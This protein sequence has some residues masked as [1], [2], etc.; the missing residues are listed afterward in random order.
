MRC[1]TRGVGDDRLAER[2]VRR[3]QHDRQD[4]GLRRRWVAEHAATTTAPSRIVSGRPKASSRTGTRALPAQRTEIDARRVGEAAP[5]RASPRPAPARPSSC[6][7]RRSRRALSARPEDRTRQ[8]ASLGSA[9]SRPSGCET[10]ATPS[11]ATATSASAHSI[12]EHAPCSSAA[13]VLLGTPRRPGLPIRSIN[14]IG[15]DQPQRRSPTGHLSSVTRPHH[16]DWM[17]PSGTTAVAGFPR[18]NGTV[19]PMARGRG[20]VILGQRALP[21]QREA[22]MESGRIDQTASAESASATEQPRQLTG[23]SSA[24]ASFQ[25]GAMTSE[26]RHHPVIGQRKPGSTR[27]LLSHPRDLWAVYVYKRLDPIFR[28]Q[29][30][31][32]VAGANSSAPVQLRPP[33]WALA[34]GLSKADL[35][36]LEGLQTDVFDQRTWTAVAWAQAFARSDFEDVPTAGRRQLPATVQHGGTGRHRTGARR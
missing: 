34:E 20:P 21:R 29:I 26:G 4:G 18:A 33:R 10:A 31:I 22:A 11:N 30:M 16:P 15:C 19:I 12:S 7:R 35:R 8:T 3:R 6:S 25:F 1:G 17:Y 9:G 5:V 23:R 32:A 2:R 13:L 24:A 36:A 28:E 27:A 14:Q